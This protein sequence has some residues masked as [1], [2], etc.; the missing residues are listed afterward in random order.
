MLDVCW[1]SLLW[2]GVTCYHFD[3]HQLC[4]G[5]RGPP[6]LSVAFCCCVRVVVLGNLLRGGMPEVPMLSFEHGLR[7]SSHWQRSGNGR[8]VC[9]CWSTGGGA[10]RMVSLGR[11]FFPC[12]FTSEFQSLSSLFLSFLFFFPS[13]FQKELRRSCQD[14]ELLSL[15]KMKTMPAEQGMILIRT[16]RIFCLFPF[17][18]ALIQIQLLRR[19]VFTSSASYSLSAKEG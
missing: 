14:H 7:S 12:D 19:K 13:S 18:L 6:N 8:E 17:L 10:N 15:M 4:I 1:G 5:I 2:Q 11:L 9:Q 16:N 3:P